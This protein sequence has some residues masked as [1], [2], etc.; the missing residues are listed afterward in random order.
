MVLFAVV[1]SYIVGSGATV[2]GLPR[3]RRLF[4]C[5]ISGD[6]PGDS[7]TGFAVVRSY[8]VRGQ[9]LQRLVQSWAIY[10]VGSGLIVGGLP[11]NRH[12]YF[13]ISG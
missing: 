1:R 6:K 8:I 12:Y 3:D 9:V 10:I 4:C 5:K 11:G 7:R 13:G 2:S